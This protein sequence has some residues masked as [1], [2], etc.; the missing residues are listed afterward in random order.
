MFQLKGYQ[1]RA[2]DVL[3]SFLTK[4]LD[5][6]VEEAY[7]LALEEQELPEFEYRDYGFKQVPYVCL[8][9]PTGGGKTVLGSYAIDVA[10]KSLL[11][12]ET[13]I[14]LWLVPSITI[15]EQTVE[16]LKKPSHP[17]RQKLDEAFKRQVLVLDIDEVTQVR[18]QDL[19]NKAIVIVSTLANLRVTDTS[20]RKIY[21]YHENFEPHFAKIPANHPLISRLE[22][23]SA[24]DVQENGLSNSA[25]GKIKYSF[26]NLLAIH[27]PIV[28]MD[29]AH[30]ARTTLTFEVL[31]R[32]HPSAIIELTATPNTSKTNGSNV[33]FHVS[34]SELKAEEMIKLPVMLTEHQNWQDAIQDAVITRNKLAIDAQKDADYIRPIALFQ[35]ENKSGEVTVDVLKT[36]LMDQLNIHEEKIAIATGNQRELDGLDLF[37]PNCKIEYIITIEALKEGWDCPFA[38]VFCSV[39]QVS[40]SKDAEQ[41]LGR[42]LRMPYA[43]R[44]LIEDLNRAYAHLSTSKFSKAAQD[45][46]DKLIAMGFEEMEV[47][48]FLR[49]ATPG[50]HNPDQQDM[51]G[52][53]DEEL[54]IKPVRVSKSLV[55]ETQSTPDLTSLSDDEKGRISMSHDSQTNTTVVRIT[56]EV[57]ESIEK[58]LTKHVKNGKSTEAFKQ[59]IRIHNQALEAEKAP[60]EKGIPFGSLPYLCMQEQGE[61]DLVESEVFL[62][63]HGWDLLDYPAEL[64][65]FSLHETSNSFSIDIDGTE[66]TYG[67]SKQ[68]NVI[69]FNQGFLD[70]T[71]QDLIGWLDRELKQPDI[72]QSQMIAFLSRIVKSL[73]QQP[74]M[75]LTAL[76]RNKFPLARA[77]RDLIRIYR[78]Q[79]QKTAYQ[80]T[81]FGDESSVCVSDQFIYEFN[82]SSYPSRPPYYTGKYKFQKHYFPQGMIEDLKTSGEE[83]ECAKVIDSLP[84]I[85]HWIRNLVRRDQSSFW[86]PLAHGKFYPDF[87]CELEDGRMLVVEYKGEAYVSNDDSAEKR[88]VGDLWA[89]LSGGKCLFIMAVEQDKDGRDVRQQILHL[90]S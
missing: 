20:G 58:A 74:N 79:A 62:H 65:N 18:P 63:A 83:Y 86:L 37:S 23:V 29:E 17:Y 48:A 38:Y 31:Q 32:V 13:P 33:L 39:K 6:D 34:A 60:S 77:I 12:T 67:I 52:A 15:R 82:P 53:G 47:A 59:N 71:E 56:G 42:V 30:N 7:R 1:Q 84:E 72:V 43:K 87:I 3:Q 68:Q 69:T 80:E 70:V 24:D 55:V 61:L 16:A 11:D 57:S 46:T 21:A 25:I 10:S 85:K 75:T 51:F 89:K 4:C 66:V 22:K 64:K 45:L 19:E 44:R 2:V 9:I 76:V 73:L 5:N 27:R 81:L 14:A 36:H 35:A 28:I 41:L 88:A 54:Q 90:I 49:E 8:R 40:S 50:I 26:A 78:K